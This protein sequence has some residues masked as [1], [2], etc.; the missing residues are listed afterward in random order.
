MGLETLLVIAMFAAFMVLLLLGF[1]VAWSLA[2]IGLV[3]A[4]LANFL[5]EHFDADLWFT[6]N[7]TI[8]VLDA[9]LYG[10]WP[11]N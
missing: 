1:P 9:R 6:W 3:F 4:V 8:G 2:G 5:I 7:G 10:W 11:M